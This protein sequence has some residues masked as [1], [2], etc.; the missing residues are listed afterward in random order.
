MAIDEA[1]FRA[2]K[3][4]ELLPTLRFYNWQ[5]PS[6]SIGYFQNVKK[7]INVEACR[8]HNID[9]VRRPTGGKAVFH[10]D[11]LTYAVIS[12]EKGFLFPQDILGT[13]KII[14][15]CIGKGLSTLG[16]NAN[17]AGPD[18]PPR[19]GY[20]DTSCFSSSSR[21]ELLVDG[22]KICGS[23]QLRS[24]GFFLQ[25]GS[26][27]IDFDPVKTCTFI[28][29]HRYVDIKK[30][31]IQLQKSITSI[32]DYVKSNIDLVELS[33]IMKGAFEEVLDIQFVEQEL[34]PL[35]NSLKTK[36]LNNKYLCDQWN[37]E[38]EIISFSC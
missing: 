15:L 1:I 7:E 32:R 5:C 10:E 22:R 29:S 30:Q 20:L 12:K 8:K 24:H 34:T 31:S 2:N 21:H 6:I 4:E 36:L 17:L 14:S 33:K 38:G 27:L 19:K 11:E 35:E 3:H 18:T 9:I 16:I 25:H 26:I 28:N 37:M 13:Y 23:A